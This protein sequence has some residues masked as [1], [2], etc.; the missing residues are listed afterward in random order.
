MKSIV[1]MLGAQDFKRI[2]VGIGRP[3][4]GWKVVDHVLAPFRPDEQELVNES[5]ELAADA[6]DDW[7][8]GQDFLKIMNKYNQRK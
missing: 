5:A 8:D 1:Q 4:G 6:L 7:V 3:Q 2:R